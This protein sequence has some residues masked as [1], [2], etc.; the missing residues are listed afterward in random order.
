MYACVESVQAVAAPLK[1][2][3]EAERR[4]SLSLSGVT[5]KKSAATSARARIT[6][7]IARGGKR[8]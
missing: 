3:Q 8:K 1:P 7:K 5:A 2:A 6:K 4:A